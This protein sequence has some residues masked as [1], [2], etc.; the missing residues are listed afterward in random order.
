MPPSTPTTDE[1]CQNQHP[2]APIHESYFAK[3]EKRFGPETD[4]M[5]LTA[6][7][8]HDHA[9]TLIELLVVIPIIAIL[10]AML[11]PALAKA[12]AKGQHIA[13][14]SNYRQLHLCWHM[15]IDDNSD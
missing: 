10:A 4:R 7:A 13:C 12:K 6:T 14:L 8:L 3:N 9:F 1:M 5:S 15:Y 11:L 2:M